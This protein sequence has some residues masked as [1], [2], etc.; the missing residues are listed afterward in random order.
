MTIVIVLLVTFLA[1]A[2]IAYGSSNIHSGMFLEAKCKNDSEEIML[3]FDDG[4]DP[5]N[6][7]KLLDVLDKYGV[8]ATFFMIGEKVD[9]YP[10]VVKEVHRRGHRIAGHTYYHNPWHNF[11]IHRKYMDELKKAHESFAKLGIEITDFRPPLGITT[12]TVASACTRMHYTVW[13]WSVRSFDTMNK[14]RKAVLA[15]IVKRLHPRGVILLHDR[16]D[17]VAELTEGV[18]LAIRE[19]GLKV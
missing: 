19:K 9:K 5:V 17:G 12:P 10:E 16:M 1:L 13:G 14:P 8:K 3:T 11:L 7:P 2:I 4:P 18:I 6:T 15:R